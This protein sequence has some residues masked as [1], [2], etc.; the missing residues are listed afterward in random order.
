MLRL[1]KTGTLMERATDVI[2]TIGVATW[3]TPE[4]Y[5]FTASVSQ[6]AALFMPVLGCIWLGVQIWSR[7]FKGK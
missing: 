2:A 6:G 3:F 7:I 4:L 1:L 5:D